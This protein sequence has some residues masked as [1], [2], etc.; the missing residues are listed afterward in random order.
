M[1]DRLTAVGFLTVVYDGRGTGFADRSVTDFSPGARVLDL[2][3]VVD[4]VGLNSFVLA[5]RDAGGSTAVAYATKHPEKVSHLIMVNAA[6]TARDLAQI[7][8]RPRIAGGLLD[9]AKEDWGLFTLTFAK[10]VNES[11]DNDLA[12]QLG[13][14]FRDSMTAAQLVAF[15]EASERVDIDSLLRSLTVP[16]L[17]VYDKSTSDARI[18]QVSLSL[19]PRIP[20]ARFV[21]TDDPAR[22]IRD[23][24]S[25]SK[26]PATSEPDLSSGTAIILFADIADSTALTERLGDTAFREKARGLDGIVR[27]VI[28]EH[29]GTP[30]EGKLLGDGVLAVFSSARQAIEAALACAAAGS[31]AGL[32]LH[33]GLH[34]GDV[35]REDNNVYGGAVNIASRISGLAAPGEVLV[36]ETVR[37]LARTSAGVAFED[38]GDQRLKG[39]S[40]AVRVWAVNPVDAS[41]AREP[42]RGLEP[43]YPDLL[44]AREVEVLRLI[45]A[46]RT[47]LEISRELVLSLRTVARHITNIYG[48][49]GARSKVDATSYAMRHNLTVER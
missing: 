38:R 42:L 10:T 7:S 15:I 30:I 40:D 37:S 9:I 8:P 29:A 1:E 35:I 4:A 41:T 48:K 27:G 5:V 14:A 49:I 11:A 12:R 3:A 2:E 19:A 26:S 45:A 25:G 21:E 47:N 44:T 18:R 36:S 24:V 33:L 32:A 31:Q 17:V 13:E 16:T 20:G 28:G 46:G 23:F 6:G 22:A 43:A 34:A 39:V